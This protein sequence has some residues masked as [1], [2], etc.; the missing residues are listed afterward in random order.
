MNT[1]KPISNIDHTALHRKRRISDIHRTLPHFTVLHLLIFYTIAQ[2]SLAQQLYLYQLLPTPSLDQ[3]LPPDA[4]VSIAIGVPSILVAFLAVWI[5]YLT[6]G[7]ERQSP[8]QA[9]L[10]RSSIHWESLSDLDL[11]PF[12]LPKQ[13]DRVYYV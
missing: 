8:R 10:P 3:M 6:L 1:W 13:P 5:A 11:T 2:R 12:R 7:R 4:I 9:S